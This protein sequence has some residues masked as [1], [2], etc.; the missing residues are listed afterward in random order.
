MV[1][2][3]ETGEHPAQRHGIEPGADGRNRP[4][5]VD[6]RRPRAGAGLRG[7]SWRRS[8]RALHA[9]RDALLRTDRARRAIRTASP[10]CIST[11]SNTATSSCSCTRSRT[12]RRIAASDCRSPR[13]PALPKAVIAEARAYLALLENPPAANRRAGTR[14]TR[15]H[16]SRCSKRRESPPP[17]MPCAISIPTR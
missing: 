4:R 15:R 5:H 16:S 1:E 8:N 2:M 14:D 17:R 12:A 3:S 6:L 9:V 10:T 7:A 11:R 13:S